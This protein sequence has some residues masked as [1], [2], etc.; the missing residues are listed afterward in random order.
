MLD[1]FSAK[2]IIATLGGRLTSA[3]RVAQYQME[4]SLRTYE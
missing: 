1:V 4:A 3:V 2:I